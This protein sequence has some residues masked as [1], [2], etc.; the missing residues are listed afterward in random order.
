MRERAKPRAWRQSVPG[1]PNRDPLPILALASS[2]G[3]YQ[4]KSPKRRPTKVPSASSVGRA[5]VPPCAPACRASGG[6]S[7][8]S[9]VT[10]L[11]RIRVD[12]CYARGFKSS[13]L[14]NLN[15]KLVSAGFLEGF[16]KGVTVRRSPEFRTWFWVDP[17]LS[18]GYISLIRNLSN[19]EL[20]ASLVRRHKPPGENRRLRAAAPDRPPWGPR[21]VR[22]HARVFFLYSF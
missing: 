8:P 22:A 3:D 1:F 18:Q 9:H 16:R 11:A 17:P 20:K 19:L 15:H 10:D 14:T 7:D 13:S 6:F 2:L 4:I 5:C 12:A 21:Q